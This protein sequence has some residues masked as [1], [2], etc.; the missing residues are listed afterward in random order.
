MPRTT[1]LASGSDLPYFLIKAL[2]QS[3][4]ETSEGAPDA[5]GGR[6]HTYRPEL[7]GPSGAQG[8]PPRSAHEADQGGLMTRF[9]L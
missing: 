4:P 9:P 5:E 1:S 8:S 7:Y 6:D 2:R 3:L